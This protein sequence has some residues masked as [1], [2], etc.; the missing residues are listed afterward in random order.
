METFIKICIVAVLGI[1]TAVLGAMW[2]QFILFGLSNVITTAVVA[3]RR[4]KK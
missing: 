3:A 4:P 1:V 2:A